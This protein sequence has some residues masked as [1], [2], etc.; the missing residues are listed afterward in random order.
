MTYTMLSVI[1]QGHGLSTAGSTLSGWPYGRGDYAVG[2]AV[3]TWRLR[4]WGVLPGYYADGG[5]LPG[6]Y[7]DVVLPGYYADGYYLGT[8]RCLVLPGYLPVPSTTWVLYYLGTVRPGS[9]T[10]WVLPVVPYVLG[11]ARGTVRPGCYPHGVLYGPTVRPHPMA[12]Y[13]PS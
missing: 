4:G 12:Y 11:T 7:A 2:V 10:S 8:S 9:C 5:V 1:E 6:Y 3:R 13:L